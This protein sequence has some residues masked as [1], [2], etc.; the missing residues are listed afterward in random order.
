M[1]IYQDYSDNDM[2]NFMAQQGTIE[3][4]GQVGD[5]STTFIFTNVVLAEVMVSE[6][7]VSTPVQNG[8]CFNLNGTYTGVITNP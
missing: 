3:I 1:V 5:E 8:Q 7:Y 6:Q 4:V 2:P